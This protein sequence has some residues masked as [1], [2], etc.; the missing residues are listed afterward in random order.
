[1]IFSLSQGKYTVEMLN[2]FGMTYYKPIPTPMVMNM[3]KPNETSS[4]LGDIDPHIYRHM[5]AS[6]MH[7]VN[8]RPDICYAVS[9][10]SQFM[11]Q[12]RKTHSIAAKHV[13][14]YLRGT[15]SYGLR[16]ASSLDMRMHGYGNADWAESAVDQQ[17]NYGCCFTLGSAMVSWCSRKQT[18]VALST[19]EA[20]YISLCVE[21]HQGVSLFK[22]LADLF[23]HEMDSTII[24]C[25]N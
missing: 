1:M 4:D 7:L 16:Y 15:I 2:N 11:S 23:G 14:R 22:I 17:S 3:K 6:L 9:V 5:I 8:I 20:E 18:F 19:I 13:L 25:D 24:H 10:L 12:P 21:V